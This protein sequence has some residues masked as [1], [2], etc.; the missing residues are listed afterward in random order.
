MKLK[1]KVAVITGGSRGIGFA[2]AQIFAQEGASIGILGRRQSSLDFAQDVLNSAAICV[3][4]DVSKIEDLDNLYKQTKA[5]FGKIDIVIANA[6]EYKPTPLETITED[7]FNE[8]IGIHFK[9][10]FF[11][12]QRAL[13]YLNQGATVILISSV[14]AYLG[15]KDFSLYN[16]CKSATISL[17]KTMAAELLSKG[18]RVN[19]ISPGMIRTSAIDELGLPEEQLQEYAKSV[20]MK[21]FGRPEEIA[22]ACLFLATDASFMTGADM[23][24]DGGMINLWPFS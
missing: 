24:I 20:P 7:T 22:Q 14:S 5:N 21:R 15:I 8:V 4:G 18:I 17:A 1:D 9:G 12:I 23:V 10:P 19:S 16:A 3:Q 2:I 6:G 13:P 11:T